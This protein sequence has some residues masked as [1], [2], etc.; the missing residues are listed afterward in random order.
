MVAE[1]P[2]EVDR[3]NFERILNE[4]FTPEEV[5]H[6]TGGMPPFMD[7]HV[8]RDKSPYVEPEEQAACVAVSVTDGTKSV[9]FR[10]MDMDA[11]QSQ[12]AHA[13]EAVR[14]LGELLSQHEDLAIRRGGELAGDF[15]AWHK[16]HR[17]MG[18]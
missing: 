12:Q 15:K 18:G 17:E 13:A 5:R 9:V 4:G 1:F 6:L 3:K 14:L 2:L 8:E 10:V 7:S 11:F 16:R